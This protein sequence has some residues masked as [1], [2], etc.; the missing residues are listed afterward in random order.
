LE[1]EG[2]KVAF[3]FKSTGEGSATALM[4]ASQ[5]F[6][7]VLEVASLRYGLGLE[8]RTHVLR[9]RVLKMKAG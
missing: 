7:D 5:A 1:R 6:L 3:S 8:K 4:L 2:D 9:Q